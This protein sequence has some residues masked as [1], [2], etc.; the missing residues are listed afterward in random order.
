MLLRPWCGGGA[1]AA[2]ACTVLLLHA[3]SLQATSAHGAG[4]ARRHRRDATTAAPGLESCDV[5]SGGWV[6][7]DGPAAAAYTG[8]NCPVIDAEFNCQMYGRPDSEYLRYRWKPAGCD[9]PR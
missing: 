6:L 5:F 2:L 3:A 4:L 8:Y 7:D 1:A 9:L